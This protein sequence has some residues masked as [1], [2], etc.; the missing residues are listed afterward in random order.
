MSLIVWNAFEMW[1][2]RRMGRINWKDHVTNEA[3]FNIVGE[4]RCL[5]E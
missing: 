5:V 1:I 2:W 3:V 4:N